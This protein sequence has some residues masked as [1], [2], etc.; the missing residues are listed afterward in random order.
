MNRC[1]NLNG[2]SV[3]VI[4]VANL[5]IL[6]G[7]VLICQWALQYKA[8]IAASILPWQHNVLALFVYGSTILGFLVVL[9]KPQLTYSGIN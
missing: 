1:G 9:I 7:I 8:E 4:V 2:M 6:I 5:P 3:P